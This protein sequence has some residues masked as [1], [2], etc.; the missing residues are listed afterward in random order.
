MGC[1]ALGADFHVPK[2]GDDP[3][4]GLQRRQEEKHVIL[5]YDTSCCFGIFVFKML[6]LLKTW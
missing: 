3:S 1:T 6:H 4:W 5:F 2:H